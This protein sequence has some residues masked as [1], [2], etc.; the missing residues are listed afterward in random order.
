MSASNPF[1]TNASGSG[2]R[3]P[4]K[5]SMFAPVVVV[6]V[7]GLCATAAVVAAS[8]YYSVDRGD[9][10]R[11]A[12]LNFDAPTELA[13][14]FTD[15]DSDLIADPP[16]DP[17]KLLDPEVL[18]FT[19][20]GSDL[21]QEEEIWKD[22]VD[23]LA[24]VTGKKV[25]LQVRRYQSQPDLDDIREGRTHIQSLNTGMVPTAVNL[26]GY[27]PV[28][29][30]ANAE[31]KFGY[32]MEIL[33][34]KDSPVQ[35]PKDLKGK[36][37]AVTSPFSLSSYRAPVVLLE[38][39][40]QLAPF[41]DYE[42]LNAGMQ[43]HAISGVAQ[44][45][46]AATAVA[47]DYMKRILERSDISPDAVRSIYKSKSFPPAAFGYTYALKPE[48]AAKVKDA[49]L[50]FDWKGTSLE[51]GYQAADQSKFV[52]VNYKEDFAGVREIDARLKSL[53]EKKN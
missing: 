21:A 9:V 47:N 45:R 17:S 20:L 4:R 18:I 2:G 25:E 26:A 6:L 50:N 49:F 43:E 39:E 48:L 12:R 53:A 36:S 3:P 42:L 29:V 51:K 16:S 1:N 10:S 11:L 35:S 24:K 14:N 7:I 34:P 8:I 40:F 41:R 32:Q 5:P 27:V 13:K 38:S 52:P 28:A 19:T 31:G 33:V 22:F 37:L 44:R 23:H 46:Y 30:M 15:A